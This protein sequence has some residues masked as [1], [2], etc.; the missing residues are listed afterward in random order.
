MSSGSLISAG[1]SSRYRVC[2]K[3][4]KKRE[5]KIHAPNSELDTGIRQ[6]KIVIL[7]AS[8]V[9]KTSIIRQFVQNTFAEEYIPTRATEVYR[10]S[11][12]IN[13]HLY[14]V[15]M[16]DCPQINS[17]PEDSIEEW[18]EFRPGK[19]VRNANAYIMVFDRSSEDSFNY[20]RTLREQM[21]DCENDHDAPLWVVC[22]KCDKAEKDSNKNGG[23][24]KR[25][26]A[27]IVKKQWKSPYLECSAKNNWHIVLL[28]KEV[29]RSIDLIE[30]GHK[31]TL[32]QNAL[33][34]KKC[35]IM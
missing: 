11:C 32:M 2:A 22:N 26:I 9:G 12:M 27:N 3:A 15:K 24:S 10:P 7:G 25:E 30:Y 19:G 35:V 6:V 23:L 33:R 20:L 14:H 16:V 4:T 29:V 17:F 13:D 28:F 8:Q 18:S 34:R 1:K 21:L 5:E 31:A